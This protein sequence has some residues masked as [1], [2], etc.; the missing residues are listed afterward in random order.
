V[1][2]VRAVHLAFRPYTKAGAVTSQAVQALHA[3]EV[4]QEGYRGK[5]VTIGILS[6][7]FNTSGD[8]DTALTDVQTGDLPH[9]AAIPGGEG[10]KALIEDFPNGTDEGRGMAQIL[11]DMA[12]SASLCFATAEGGEVHFAENIKKLAGEFEGCNADV[13]VD[14]IGYFGEPFFSDGVITEAINH[15]ATS[16]KSNGRR[17]VYFSAAGN[18]DGETYGSEFRKVSVARAKKLAG[19]P[20]DLSTIPSSI[21]IGGG[22]HD[23]DPAGKVSIIQ[24]LFILGNPILVFQWNDPFDAGGITTSYSLLLFD[25]SGRFIASSDI[26]SNASGAD[27]AFVTDE[28]IQA[29]GFDTSGTQGFAQYYLAIARSSHGSQVANQLEYTVFDGAI[30]APYLGEINTPAVYGHAGGRHTISVAAYDV[31][32][33][34]FSAT[35][36]FVPELEDYT[37][38]GPVRIFFDDNGNRLGRPEVRRKPD[39]ACVDG[40]F[41]TFFG[42]FFL[43]TDNFP[44]FFGTSAAAPCAAGIGALM[45]DK[46]RRNGGPGDLSPGEIKDTM[47][48]SAPRHDADPY[49]AKGVS[50]LGDGGRLKVAVQGQS[51][52]SIQV[53]TDFTVSLNNAPHMSLTDLK[54]H[55]PHSA[56]LN[57]F[58]NLD[59]SNNQSN[60]FPFVIGS[61]SGGIVAKL[62][63]PAPAG[64]GF[65]GQSPDL[66]VKF[67]GF[68]SGGFIQ[69]DVDRLDPNVGYLD[70]DADRLGNASYTATLVD[71]GGRRTTV[72]GS[73]VN[74]LNHEWTPFDGFGLIDAQDAVGA[75]P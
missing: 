30:I 24:P 53:P 66:E 68:H 9:T 12:P 48:D 1:A 62:A 58:I 47:I 27:N 5:G 43:P 56:D 42:Q 4:F 15:V 17:T 10:L 28:P 74:E 32:R 51:Q 34:P 25:S 46:A 70:D 73:I 16:R 20:V 65:F 54:I 38:P 18:N 37:S 23:F 3:N 44:R 59:Q 2:G 29:I 71:G 36:P 55:L 40:V 19:L 14:D 52:T 41:T 6:D 39:I 8:P 11:H 21:D 50:F 72:T 33:A 7:S 63:S 31:N 64:G 45:L 60:Y 22:F 75:V 69:F 13:L 67:S 57:F 61:Q 35:A 26:D 49:F